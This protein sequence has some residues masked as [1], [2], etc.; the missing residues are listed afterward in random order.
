MNLQRMDAEQAAGSE[1]TDALMF[2]AAYHKVLF[3]RCFDVCVRAL[4]GS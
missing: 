2:L 3:L 4:S 1:A